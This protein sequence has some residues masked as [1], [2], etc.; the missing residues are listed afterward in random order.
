M[1]KSLGQYANEKGVSF[2]TAWRHYKAGKIPNAEV[3]DGKVVI[4]DVQVALAAQPAPN[5]LVK[6]NQGTEPVS[7]DLFEGVKMTK[8]STRGN[9]SAITEPAHRFQNIAD[10]IAPFSKSDYGGNTYVS[11]KDAVLL[12]QKCYY[13]FSIYRNIIDLMV[14]FA[15]GPIYLTKGNKKTRD[16]FDSYFKA[17]NMNGFQRQFFRELFRSCN[18]FTYTLN[19][20]LNDNAVNEITKEY[21]A[22]LSEGA[23]Y[24][25]PSKYI[26]LNPTDILMGGSTTF[27]APVLYKELTDYEVQRLREAKTDED[28]RIFDS[29]A[30]EVKKQIKE[31]VS[32]SILMPLSKKDLYYVAY[33]KQDYEPFAVPLGYCVLDDINRKEEMKRM[34]AQICRTMQQVVL[35]VKTGYESKNGDYTVNAKNIEALKTIFENQSVGRVL[36]AD[37]TT[38]AKFVIPEIG[39]ILDPKKYEVLDRDIAIG[40]NN[41]ISGN[42]SGEKY[43]NKSISVEIFVE[44]LRQA[45]EIFKDE[46]L[47]PEIKRI[48]KE[49]GF[50]TYPKP[51]FQEIRL[52]DEIDYARIYTRLAEIGILTPSETIEAINTYKLPNPE[53]SLENQAKFVEYKDKGFYEPLIGGVKK[54]EDSAKVNGRPSGTPAPQTTKKIKPL[55]GSDEYSLKKLTDNIKA[56]DM[57]MAE[58]KTSLKKKFKL[59]KLSDEQNEVAEDIAACII[60]NE[61]VQSWASKMPEYLEKPLDKNPDRV[62]EIQGLAYE[63][64]LD[65]YTASLLYWSKK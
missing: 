57:L 63:F 58:I 52:K 35:L 7:V 55:G 4:R 8:A 50:K 34:D 61:E 51:D 49:L 48:S 47:I 3:V 18:V 46:F 44:R 39:D 41:I 65:D 17:I 43:S 6:L 60:A 42:T 29:L 24:N 26:V 21:G 5:P 59:K 28:K 62:K 1:N 12:C 2:T 56:A 20:K 37:F 64:Q 33:N 22:S 38:D 9:K 40:L 25:I 31:K 10:G 30:P 32:T 19:V 27:L 16:F 36:V 23:T 11:I 15:S 14:E 53:E 45:R 54:E 13:N